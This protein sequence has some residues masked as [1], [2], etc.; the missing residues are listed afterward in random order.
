MTLEE[1]VEALELTMAKMNIQHQEA[2]AAR[3]I[4]RKTSNEVIANARRPGGILNTAQHQA[5]ESTHAYNEL[6]DRLLDNAAILTHDS[7]S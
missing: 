5:A 1:R 6:R 2:D 3:G 7:R 4:A